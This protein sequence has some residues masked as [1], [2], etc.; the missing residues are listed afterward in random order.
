MRADVL[1]VLCLLLEHGADVDA[2]GKDG[3]TPLRLS[4]ER[5]NDKVTQLLLEY[6]NKPMSE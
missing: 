2:E 5:G 1:D 4:L 3:K 6:S